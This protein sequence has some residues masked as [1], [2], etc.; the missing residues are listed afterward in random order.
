MVKA[1]SLSPGYNH[2]CALD[3]NGAAWCWGDNL[4]GQMGD[5]TMRGK[6]ACEGG[7]LYCVVN[8][9]SVSALGL[10]KLAAIS[11]DVIRPGMGR[12]LER[13]RTPKRRP[14]RKS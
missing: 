13:T 12:L 6:S 7:A 9:T 14:G 4:W 11:V 3:E 1:V 2:T 10:P 8:A 5:G